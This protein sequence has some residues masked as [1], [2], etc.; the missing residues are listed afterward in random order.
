MNIIKEKVLHKI[1][2][3]IRESTK[4]S[5]FSY[6]YKSDILNM[7][8]NKKKKGVNIYEKQYCVYCI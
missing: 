3:Y 8:K 5:T 2:I 4:K 1:I 6:F 7:I